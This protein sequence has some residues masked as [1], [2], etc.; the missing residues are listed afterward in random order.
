MKTAS[1]LML[2]SLF[3]IGCSK[4]TEKD[5]VDCFGA[6]LL[7][8]VHHTTSNENPKTIHFNVSYSGSSTLKNT[9]TWHYG[10]GT[11]ET[12][13]G[14]STSHTYSKAGAYT[15]KAA[16]SFVSPSCTIEV[17]ENVEIK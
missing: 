14:T 7:T 16:V 1:T 9:I 3:I 4:D 10:D 6:S 8:N 13:K 2:I 12:V 11:T 5:I 15:V 17:K